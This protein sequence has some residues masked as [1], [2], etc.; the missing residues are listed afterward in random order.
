MSLAARA[1]AQRT[2]DQPIPATRGL[3]YDRQGSPAR[4]QRRHVGRQDHA[5]RPAVLRARRRHPAPRATCSAWRRRRSSPR[6]TPRPAR[7]STRSASPQ[8][9]PEETARLV[10]ESSDELPGVQVVV[11][12]RR[13]YPDGP[14]LAHIL[15][16]TGPI[17]GGTYAKLRSEGYLAD[18][19]IGK[20]GVE[21]TFESELRGHV[22][23]RGRREGRDRQ[24]HPGPVQQAGGRPGCLAH[25]H[26]RQDH[27]GARPRR[28]SSGA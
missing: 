25:A 15:G 8:D 9:V 24:G 10:A 19:L 20:T 28:R 17:D 16:Y 14:L 27:P 1:E 21:S 3:I 18:D 22:R 6:S 7:G 5:V 12:T 4:Q 2:E 23:H 11:E 26:D 13:E